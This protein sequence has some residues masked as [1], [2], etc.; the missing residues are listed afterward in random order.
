MT[1]SICGG[2]GLG[3][4]L[5]AAAVT[6]AASHGTLYD[7]REGDERRGVD[8]TFDLAAATPPSSLDAF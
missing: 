4:R 3:V 5:V 7:V 6:I 8:V 1:T 2:P